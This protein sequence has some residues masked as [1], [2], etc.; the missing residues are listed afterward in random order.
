MT[1]IAN[2]PGR[3]QTIYY[4]CIQFGR[5]YGC[6]YV[7]GCVCEQQYMNVERLLMLCA[8]TAGVSIYDM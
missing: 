1:A 2:P 5:V 4:D 7:F 6:V 3:S 8:N